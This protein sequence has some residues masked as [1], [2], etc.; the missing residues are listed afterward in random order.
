[1]S[2]KIEKREVNVS[3]DELLRRIEENEIFIGDPENLGSTMHNLAMRMQVTNKIRSLVE[4]INKGESQGAAH[5]VPKVFR[6]LLK[7]ALD[8]CR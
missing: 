1:M 8:L 2:Y 3:T 6:D 7:F 4:E 5:C